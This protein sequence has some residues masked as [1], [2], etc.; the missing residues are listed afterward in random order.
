MGD[1]EGGLVVDFIAWVLFPLFGSF[2]VY[3][4][5]WSRL[6]GGEMRGVGMMSV[7][8]RGVGRDGKVMMM[9]MVQERGL[10][11]SVG[12]CCAGGNVGGV[13]EEEPSPKIGKLMEEIL[14]LNMLEVRELTSHLKVSL[15][16]RDVKGREGEGKGREVGQEDRLCTFDLSQMDPLCVFGLMVKTKLGVGDMPMGM[17]MVVPGGVPGGPAAGAEA[18]A[19]E[20]APVEEKTVFV[21]KLEAFDQ[22]KKIPV[23]A[24]M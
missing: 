11:I 5:L 2:C 21:V 23:S 16:C 13:G 15:S 8:R 3:V 19:E 9:R 6:S 22:N 1:R 7:M 24:T 20:P 12:R 18:A 14:A 10:R 4:M 17:P